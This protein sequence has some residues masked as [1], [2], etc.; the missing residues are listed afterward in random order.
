MS[1]LLFL[2]GLG[3][4]FKGLDINKIDP[5]LQRHTLKQI[6]KHNQTINSIVLPEFNLFLK[7]I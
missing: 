2:L 4:C 5:L 1:F 3:N 6:I 7:I